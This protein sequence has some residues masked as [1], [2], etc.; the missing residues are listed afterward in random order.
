MT[1]NLNFW[2]DNLCSTFVQKR[3]SLLYSSIGL[4]LWTFQSVK[5]LNY[6][7]LWKKCSSSILSRCW[8]LRVSRDL[9]I[10]L[11][12][13]R[14]HFNNIWHFKAGMHNIRPTGQMWP[15]QSFNTARATLNFVYFACYFDNCTF[16]MC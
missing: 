16:W 1:L 15:G 4:T 3:G 9:Q 5:V 13:K 7:N 6:A 8:I 11:N 2:T 14:D 12:T 10:I